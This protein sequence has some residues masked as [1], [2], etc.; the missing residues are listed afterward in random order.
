MFCEAYG[1]IGG[2][3][4]LTLGAMGGLYVSGGVISRFA[5]SFATRGCR[6]KFESKGR[7]RSYLKPISV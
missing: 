7:F 1:A 5:T 6:E 3:L 2:T 4:A